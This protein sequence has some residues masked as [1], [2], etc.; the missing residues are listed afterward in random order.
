MTAPEVPPADEVTQGWWAATTEHRLVVQ[1]CGACDGVQHPPR[2]LCIHCGSTERLGWRTAS[3]T[4][5]VDSF[6]VVHRAP[7]AGIEVPYVVARVRLD[8]GP[9]LLTRLEGRDPG[10]EWVVDD[11][12]RVAWAD[13]PDGRALPVFHPV[14]GEP[15]RA[16]A[17][18]AERQHRGLPA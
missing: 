16:Q 2:A 14:E 3:G 8:E 13:L 15:D 17:P 11:R 12:V 7:R 1:S 9:I 4:G 6:T 10:G 5:T 18:A